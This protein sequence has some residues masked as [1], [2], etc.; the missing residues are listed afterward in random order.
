MQNQ[1]KIG[2]AQ[3]DITPERPVYIAGQLFLRISK[4]IHDPLTATCLVLENGEEQVTMVSLDMTGVPVKQLPT[5]L[6]RLCIDGI[7]KDK[8][9]FNA[10]HTHNSTSFYCDSAHESR[11][12]AWLGK[13]ILP[14][15]DEP[16]NILKGP[17]AEA[18]LVEKIVELITK[19]WE[20]RRLG[21]ISAAH[22]YAVVAFNRRPVFVTQNG[23]LESKMYGDCSE[24]GFQGFEGGSDN[25]ADMLYTWDEN[26]NLTGVLVCIPC[27]SQVFELQSFISADYW[28]Y[29]RESIRERLGNVFILPLCGPAGDQN[30]IDLARI[31]KMNK[32]TLPVWNAQEQAVVCNYDMTQICIDI[33]ERISEAVSRGYSKAQN[34]IEQRP[35]FMLLR[36]DIKL[37]VRKVSQADY[38][39]AKALIDGVKSSHST[40]N[41]LTE[42]EMIRLFEPIGYLQRWQQQ[43]SS[44]TLTFP[45]FAM[46]IG[47]V[48][49]ATNP[50]ELFVDFGL[51]IKA[52]SRANQVVLV[53]LSS[54]ASGGY[55]PTRKAIE[56]GSYS[57]KPVSTQIGP[58]GGDE[59]VEATITAINSLFV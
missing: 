50:F 33:G 41:R 2:W 57:A 11:F 24:D 59:L 31:S 36:S 3:T 30:P 26:S 14:E 49:I 45:V 7:D 44:P 47:R 37:N 10:I 40:E 4:Y 38:L 20:S 52:R 42:P 13:D 23:K 51:R 15:A 54:N 56:G 16:A 27:P 32:E 35:V 17:E 12:E 6:D 46:R 43:N 1:M 8:V 18:F 58:E 19:A 53:Q 5:I 29:A 34:R 48:A 55:L 22:D 39:T 28:C 9:I 21:G 25:S